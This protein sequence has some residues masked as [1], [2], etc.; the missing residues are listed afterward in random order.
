MTSPADPT[1]LD[2]V[3]LEAAKEAGYAAY[4]AFNDYGRLAAEEACEAAIRA[5]LESAA[6]APVVTEEIARVQQAQNG[7][8]HAARSVVRWGGTDDRDLT[9][10]RR[11]LE[12]L[13][14]A[15]AKQPRDATSG[16]GT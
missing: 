9:D 15:L 12:R 16:E 13:D 6:P 10:L 1:P 8:A 11:A 7:L 14:A 3:R 4:L 2:P 5:Y